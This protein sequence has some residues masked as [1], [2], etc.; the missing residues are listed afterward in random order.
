MNER[1]FMISS[2]FYMT[3]TTGFYEGALN[4]VFF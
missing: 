3:V 4:F 1:K 2:L